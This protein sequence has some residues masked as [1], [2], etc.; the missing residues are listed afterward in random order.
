MQTPS[1]NKFLEAFKKVLNELSRT[2]YDPNV[3]NCVIGGS[4]ALQLHGL[5]LTREPSDLDIIIFMPSAKQMY[6]LDIYFEPC[7]DYKDLPEG[8]EVRSFYYH[9]H[10]TGLKLNVIISD[11]KLPTNLMFWAYSDLR[12][13]KVNTIDNIIAA[14]AQYAAGKD[15]SFLRVKDVQDLLDLKSNNFNLPASNTPITD[16]AL[17]VATKTK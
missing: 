11:D 4:C 16:A 13:F 17:A 5:N 12:Y 1:I 8:V 3:N 10:K 2:G 15:K 7:A 6:M 14:K 9:D